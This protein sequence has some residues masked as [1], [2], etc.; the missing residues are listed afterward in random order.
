MTESTTNET[1]PAPEAVDIGALVRSS[2]RAETIVPI[3][4]R[5]DLAAELALL[6]RQLADAT[7]AAVAAKPVQDDRLNTP[8]DPRQQ[9][10]AERIIA[11]QQE[12]AASTVQFRLRALA[13]RRW[14][15]L[16]AEHPPRKAADGSVDDRDRSGFHADTF[17]PALVR[18]SVVAPVIDGDTWTLL[19]EGDE[20]GAGLSDGQYDA[21]C[22]AAW[23]LNRRQVD[24]PF[25]RAA[26]AI[27][28]SSSPK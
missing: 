1:A 9:E 28:R 24:V 18:E 6:E 27:L 13:P 15:D 26:S 12:M 7:A 19:L 3:C 20:D 5:G 4:L 14:H 16:V 23:N 17:W 25:S 8:R 11:L 21:L 10:L 22:T 2:R